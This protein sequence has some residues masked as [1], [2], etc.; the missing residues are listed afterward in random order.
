MKTFFTYL[1]PHRYAMMLQFTIKFIGSIM[2]LFLPWLLAF[3]IDTI[4]PTQNEGRIFLYG[5]IMIGCA[6]VAVAFNIIANRM[7]IGISRKITQ[8]LRHDLFEKVTF[9]S[10]KQSDDI[11]LPSL[12]SRLTSDTYHVHQMVDRMQRLGIRAPILLLGGIV[13][14]LSLEPVLTLVLLSTLPILY[15]IIR[16]VSKKGV[17]LY[18]KTQEANDQLVRKVQENITGMRVI[19]ALSKTEYEKT[20]FDDI[21]KDLVEKDRKA[22]VTMAITSPTMTLLINLGLSMVILVGAFRVNVNL[23]QPGQIIAFLSYFTIIL[24][25]LLMV[26]R[27]FTLYSKGAASANRMEE[28]LLLQ[29][30]MPLSS[31]SSSYSENHIEFQ[32]VSF[33]YNK[34]KNNL[35]NISFTLKANETLGI[36]GETGSGK[37]TIIQL[38]LRFYDVDQGDILI[39]GK[40]IQSIPKETLHQMFGVVFQQDILFADTIYENIRFGRD[41]NESA[42]LEAAKVAQARFI[43]EKPDGIHHPLTIKG[44]NLSGG[45]KQRVLIA[46]ALAKKP[47]ILIFDDSASALDYLTESAWRAAMAKHYPKTTTIMVAQRIASV[48]RLDK[49][50]MLEEGRVIG[51]GT[52]Q[53]LLTTCPSYQAIYDAQMGEMQL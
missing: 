27:I 28:I 44:S 25:A 24:T 1:K 14:T 45:Q 46:R 29:E 9:L 21:N 41:I 40:P 47:D 10:A 6:L 50:L 8:Q 48:M 13:M 52:H 31:T 53:E 49:I 37:S 38:L 5:G 42:V 3:M 7:S 15:L 18:R 23:T 20:R 39:H 34:K 51:Y 16:Y 22:S 4:V 36:I 26:T 30:D 17:V 43:H 35:E 32:H 33:S 19:K 12:L 11:T 2:D